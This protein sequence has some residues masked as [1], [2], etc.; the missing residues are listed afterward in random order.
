MANSRLSNGFG[1]RD[2]DLAVYRLDNDT[3]ACGQNNDS[4]TYVCNAASNYSSA[5]IRLKKPLRAQIFCLI[6]FAASPLITPTPLVDEECSMSAILQMVIVQDVSYSYTNDLPNVLA[7][8]PQLLQELDTMFINRQAAV[9]SFSDRPIQPFGDPNG[10]YCYKEDHRFSMV[11]NDI[12][13]ALTSLTVLSGRDWKESQL[14]AIK[15]TAMSET[16]GWY[17]Q[18]EV[19]GKKVLRSM[20]LATDS[21]PHVKGDFIAP[22]NFDVK[23]P[24]SLTNPIW[25]CVN[26]DYPSA[27]DIYDILTD[28]GMHLIVIATSD[29]YPLWS[30]LS[31][32]WPAT[33]IHLSDPIEN[34]IEAIEEALYGLCPST[35]TS[36]SS[37]ASSPQTLPTELFIAEGESGDSCHEIC[38]GTCHEG[39]TTL[40]NTYSTTCLAAS[41]EVFP[42]YELKW[43]GFTGDHYYFA[44]GCN[45]DLFYEMPEVTIKDIG[46]PYGCDAKPA[47]FYMDAFFRRLCVCSQKPNYTP[48]HGRVNEVELLRAQ[49]YEGRS[50][51][52]RSSDQAYSHEGAGTADA[53]DADIHFRTST[54]FA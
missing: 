28:Y 11:S 10:D 24:P 16:L 37:P 21:G 13:D 25:D 47:P 52:G 31:E 27:N 15:F 29:V 51:D 14:D 20:I 43:V 40:I 2:N 17:R 53:T 36:T 19:L 3:A 26:M 48:S 18:D 39:G 38:E 5:T 44:S 7:K 34:V 9:V 42:G 45:V 33:L 6:L 12:I 4:D 35:T 32:H 22:S 23:P 1:E 46:P 41:K 50:S 49:A 54:N 8:I 30:K